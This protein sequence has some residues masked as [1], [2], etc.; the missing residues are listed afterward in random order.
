M[1]LTFEQRSALGAFIRA[2]RELLSPEQFGL[3]ARRRSR[4]PGLRREEVAQLAGVSTTWYT[5]LEQGRDMSMSAGALARLA[6]ALALN[7]AERAYLFELSRHR[8]PQLPVVS[9]RSATP[10]GMRALVEA[11]RC[12]AYVIDARWEA[13]CWNEPAGELLRPWLVEG[14]ASLLRY[15]FLSA[16]ARTFISDW[17][18][19]ARRLLAEFRAE[20]ARVPDDPD[21]S[22]L[23]VELSSAS[24]DFARLWNGYHVLARE[25]GMRTFEHPD[26]GRIRAEQM[27]LAVAGYPDLKLIV[28]LPAARG[29]S[30]P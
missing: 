16:S 27:T 17:E 12:P 5:W 28:L 1:L 25:G 2:R 26:Q 15:M 23:I 20:T 9:G 22:A 11:I 10:D 30:E 7:G 19:R 8:D 14:E 29:A 21:A 3:P 18:D 24:P 13:Q 4:T 6:D